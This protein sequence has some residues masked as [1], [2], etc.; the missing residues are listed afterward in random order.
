MEARLLLEAIST[1]K[2]GWPAREG[3][4]VDIL[5]KPGTVE[6]KQRPPKAQKHMFSLVFS[7]EMSTAI[8]ILAYKYWLRW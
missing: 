5:M 1:G 2:R 6:E 4:A 8:Y 7:P 3:W